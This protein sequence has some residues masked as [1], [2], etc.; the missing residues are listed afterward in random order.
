MSKCPNCGAPMQNNTC[1]YC[2]YTEASNNSNGNGGGNVVINNVYNQQPQGTNV[3]FVNGVSPKSKM[4]ALLL[5]IFLG[6]FGAHK[7]YVGKIGSGILYLFTCG[8]F[9]IGWFIDIILILCGSFKDSNN[10]PLK[11]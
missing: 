1:S 4:T 3:V 7:F 11:K 5:C 9:G 6:Y 2:H 8:I 10:M